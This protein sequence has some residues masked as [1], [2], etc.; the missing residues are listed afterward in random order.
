LERILTELLNNAYKYTPAGE[1]ITLA[2][3]VKPL[4]TNRLPDEQQAATHATE[5]AADIA[6][7]RVAK[8]RMALPFLVPDLFQAQPSSQN[9]VS[10]SVRNSGTEIAASDLNRIFDKFY[11]IPD[12]DPWN[13]GGTGLGL[14]LVKQMVEYLGGRIQVESQNNTTQFTLE[15]AIDP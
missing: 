7:N 11:R 9:Y 5:I 3:Q 4:Q 15:L 6:V 1:T 10:I 12:I 2:A 8:P 13:H 14:A